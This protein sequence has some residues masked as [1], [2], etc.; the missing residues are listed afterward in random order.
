MRGGQ[1][2]LYERGRV[3]LLKSVDKLETSNQAIPLK[4]PPVDSTDVSERSTAGKHLE[5]ASGECGK[6]EEIA[7]SLCSSCEPNSKVYEELRI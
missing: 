5:S 3:I 7:Q 6:V 4:T 2:L 1:H